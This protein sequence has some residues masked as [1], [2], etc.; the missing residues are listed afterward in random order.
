MLDTL[1]KAWAESNAGENI[2]SNS[3]LK[4]LDPFTKSGVFL[5]E[6]ATRLIKGLE[7]EIP[8]LQD[9]VDHILTKQVY[10]IATTRLTSL[11]ARRSLYCSKK[12]NGKHSVTKKFKNENGNI[13]FEPLTHTWNKGTV[14]ELTMDESG[15]EVERYVD[16]KCKHCGASKRDFDRQEGLELHAYGLIHSDD[17]QKWVGEIF[18]PDMQFDVIIGNPPYQLEDGGHAA[19]AS[20]IYDKF[21]EQALKLSPRFLTM[22]IP[23]R[24]FSGGKGLSRFRKMMLNSRQIVSLEDYVLDKDAFPSVNVN[25]GVCYFLWDSLHSGDTYLSTVAPGGLRLESRQRN[26]GE[27]DVL[28]RWN[29]A[30]PILRNV[31]S[32]TD[33]YFSDLVCSHRPFGLRSNY[34][35]ADNPSPEKQVLLIGSKN[36]SWVSMDEITNNQNLV[37]SWKVLIPRASD[38]NEKYPLPIWDLRGAVVSK[39]G[40]ACTETYLV[41][42][43]AASEAEANNIAQFLNTKFV[44]FLVSLR[45]PTQDNKAEIFSFVPILDFSKSWTDDHLF[46]LFKVP[47][48]S[49]E[50][51]NSLIRDL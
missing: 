46:Q 43:K 31:Q 48:P 28:V 16:G 6:I 38:G 29:D 22:V 30:M 42:A 32:L 18:G 44:R 37:S 10:G 21:V 23:S 25:G 41:A 15:K 2:W 4:F 12:A 26:L 24:W 40:E 5:R 9:R 49:V 7:S 45:K 39:P 36:Q 8:D 34:V 14:V 35:G 11:M 27:F 13:W 19:S 20:P 50:F 1:E 17:P 33:K 51:I 3:N 47:K